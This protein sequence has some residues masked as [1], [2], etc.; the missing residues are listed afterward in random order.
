MNL[1]IRIILFFCLVNWLIYPIA[2]AEE[3]MPGNFTNPAAVKEVLSGKRTVANAA[4]WGFNQED[5]TDALQGAINSGASKVIV[6][7]TGSAWIVR[8][9]NLVSNLE[10]IFEP[11]VVVI[12]KKGEFRGKNDCL[13]SAVGKK[14]IVLRGYGATLKMQ[15][16]DYMSSDYSKSEFRYILAFRICS[17]IKVLGLTL[18]DSGGDGIFVGTQWTNR[19]TCRNILIKDCI[20]DNNYRQGISIT[21][22]ENLLIENCIL[23]NTN[24]TGPSAGID[25]EPSFPEEK[26]VNVVVNNCISENNNGPGFL[27]YLAKLSKKSEDVSILFV[28][29][30]V[31]GGRGTGI[32]IG[33]ARDEGPKGLV[34]FRNCTIEDIDYSG[35]YIYDKSSTGPLLQ[36]NNC[37]W[38]NVGVKGVYPKSQTSIPF[39]FQTV[40]YMMR[41]IVLLCCSKNLTAFVASLIS[42]V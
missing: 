7:Y 2:F 39:Y 16:N 32:H 22:A 12:A 37:K 19:R 31:K 6:P 11:G 14:N 23:K 36:F 8:P 29:C 4:W 20:C 9:I 3:E 25:L 17:E 1:K 27:V 21:C 40:T 13:F 42:R 34:E 24:G 33:P 38:Y 18:K 30:H 35:T 15:K 28:N 26:M 41:K 5:S 10:L